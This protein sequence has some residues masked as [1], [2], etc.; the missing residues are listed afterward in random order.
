[1]GTSITILLA[2]EDHAFE[3]KIKGLVN[4]LFFLRGV[5]TK[6]YSKEHGHAG[7]EKRSEELRSLI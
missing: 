6:S 1:M 5:L 3:P 2:K 7:G 4:M